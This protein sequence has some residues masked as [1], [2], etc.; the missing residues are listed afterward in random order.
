M[1]HCRG[2]SGNYFCLC[3][4]GLCLVL[5]ILAHMVS[6]GESLDPANITGWVQALPLL[7]LEKGQDPEHILCMVQ[8]VGKTGVEKGVGLFVHVSGLFCL[9]EQFNIWA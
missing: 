1:T 3:S 6:K 5:P 8:I 4:V 7:A 2:G 9:S